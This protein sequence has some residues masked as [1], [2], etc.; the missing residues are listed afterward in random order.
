[1]TEQ[2]LEELE[3]TDGQL[4]QPFAAY[5]PSRDQ[6]ELQVRR[7]QPKHF[8]RTTATQQGS[9]PREEL[10]EGKRLDQVVIGAQIQPKDAVVHA[11]ASGQDQNGR[12]NVPLPER[13]QNLESVPSG[14][15]QIENKQVEH[16]C[17]S[18]KKP[19]FTGWGHYDV[20][21]FRLQG[22]RDDL[23]QLALVF[24]DENPH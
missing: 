18:A 22:R 14:Q 17:I 13:L 23:R 8:R 16:F 5:R 21:V 4:E 9:N 15:H 1:M 20:V 10:R 3:L 11:V 12:L 19:I 6:V 2:I 24:D 7:L